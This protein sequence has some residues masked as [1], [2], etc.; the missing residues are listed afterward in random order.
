MFFF[1]FV[2]EL[3]IINEEVSGPCS[4]YRP[5]DDDL[6]TFDF[7]RQFRLDV[8]ETQY[9]GVT[10]VRGS[11]RM[12]TAYRLDRDADLTLPTRLVFIFIIQTRSQKPMKEA[13]CIIW[14]FY[15]CYNLIYMYNDFIFSEKSIR[16]INIYETKFKFK[17]KRCQKFKQNF[18]YKYNLITAPI[19]KFLYYRK[20]NH[21]NYKNMF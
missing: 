12:Q 20:I 3:N 7:I 11:N 14:T 15:R 19:F 16:N 13:I 4:N 8:L 5:G 10:R 21:V 2:P 18:Y 9:P 17:N 6:F 1:Y